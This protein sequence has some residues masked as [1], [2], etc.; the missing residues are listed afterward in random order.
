MDEKIME[1][2]FSKNF[3]YYVDEERFVWEI[4]LTK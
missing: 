2:A 4:N 3:G 1:C